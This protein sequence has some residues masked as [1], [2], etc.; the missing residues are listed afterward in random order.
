MDDEIAFLMENQTCVLIEL[1]ES[2]RVLHNKWVYRLK[3]ENDA[4]EGTRQ[5]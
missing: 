2:K 4:P 5:C 1:P 3:E